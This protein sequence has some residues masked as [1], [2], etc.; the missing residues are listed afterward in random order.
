MEK[1][2]SMS[3]EDKLEILLPL[4]YLTMMPPRVYNIPDYRLF[5]EWL[6]EKPFK[7]QN[8][9]K[10]IY[11]PLIQE[12]LTCLPH[13]SICNHFS[14]IQSWTNWVLLWTPLEKQK[15]LHKFLLSSPVTKERL[16]TAFVNYST[17]LYSH[18]IPARVSSSS[19]NSVQ[20]T[21][22]KSFLNP[23]SP[24]ALATL[25]AMVSKRS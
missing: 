16:T 23:P 17:H 11:T 19:T 20:P 18:Y 12:I 2:I 22:Q 10:E 24:S 13:H 1:P 5:C 25:S 4:V 7:A 9:S 14:M 15:L 6:L 3:S 21:K 8:S